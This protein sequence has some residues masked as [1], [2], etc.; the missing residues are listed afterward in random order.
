MPIGRKRLRCELAAERESPPSLL[1]FCCIFLVFPMFPEF[2]LLRERTFIPGTDHLICPAIVH[3]KNGE[4]DS[5]NFTC[6]ST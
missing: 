1:R 6:P 2:F 5:Y 4:I 3:K